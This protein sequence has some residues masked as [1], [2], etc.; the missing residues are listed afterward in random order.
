MG[1]ML[2][3]ESQTFTGPPTMPYAEETLYLFLLFGSKYE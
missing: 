1:I 3:L 2:V